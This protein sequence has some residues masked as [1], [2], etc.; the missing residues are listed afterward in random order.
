MNKWKEVYD[1]TP[2][3]GNYTTISKAD[4]EILT[5]SQVATEFNLDASVSEKVSDGDYLYELPVEFGGTLT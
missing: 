1:F 3:N 4:F 2:A 5:F